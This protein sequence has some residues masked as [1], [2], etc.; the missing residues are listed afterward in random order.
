MIFFILISLP[1]LSVSY[2]LFSNIPDQKALKIIRVASVATVILIAAFGLIGWIITMGIYYQII[3]LFSKTKSF[4]FRRFLY[5]A[6]CLFPV[7]ALIILTLTFTFFKA[8]GF[9]GF[10]LGMTAKEIESFFTS[11]NTAKSRIEIFSS[12]VYLSLLASS[13]STAY[14]ESNKKMLLTF[15]IP[16]TIWIIFTALLRYL[17]S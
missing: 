16:Y 13:I 12:Y 17:V 9:S 7:K 3:K 1:A 4:E 2:N 14:G 11:W 10:Q 15:L 6:G 8:Y 5:I